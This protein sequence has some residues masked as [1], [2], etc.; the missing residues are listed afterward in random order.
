MLLKIYH[1]YVLS[2]KHGSTLNLII[3]IIMITKGYKEPWSCLSCSIMLFPFGNLSN[4]N[5]LGFIN[6]IN[7]NNSDN[8]NNNNNNNK[9]LKYFS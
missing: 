6:N 7:N 2:V 4:K 1:F 3:L 5:C 8:N 9:D